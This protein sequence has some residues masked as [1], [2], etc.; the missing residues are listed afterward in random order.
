MASI[1]E[2]IG[3]LSAEIKS[4]HRD[5]RKIRQTLEDPSGEKAEARSRNNGFKKPINVSDH[6]REFLGLEPGTLISRS[7]VTQAINKYATENNLKDGQVIKM[8]DKLKAILN[9]PE[10]FDMTFMKLQHYLKIHYVKDPPPAE[11]AEQ[12]PAP[13][14]VRKPRVKKN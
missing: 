8:D 9:P 10:G 7:D 4:L 6:L 1:D 13:V 3:K 2:L 5:V 11:E 12:T 14:P